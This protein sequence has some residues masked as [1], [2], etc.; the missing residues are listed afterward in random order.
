[1]IKTIFMDF[2]A[3][4]DS[5]ANRKFTKEQDECILRYYHVKTRRDFIS[6]FSKKYFKIGHTALSTRYK[7]L[8]EQI[9]K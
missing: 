8:S 2:D 1:M 4:P 7:K 9:K 5:R 3:L 6:L